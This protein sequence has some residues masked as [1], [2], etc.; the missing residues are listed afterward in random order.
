MIGSRAV[1]LIQ[2]KLGW[3]SDKAAE[4]LDELQDAQQ[5]L[6][7]GVQLPAV[8]G[9]PSSLGTFLPSFLLSEISS[10]ATQ[11]GEER[12][13]I[14]TDFLDEAE[15][16]ALWYFNPS[17]DDPASVWTV[18]HKDDIDFLRGA[19]PGSGPPQAYAF[20]GTY[21]RIFPTPDAVYTLKILYYK[22]DVLLDLTTENKWLKNIPYLLIGEAG[23]ELAF[24]LRDTVA[25]QYFDKMS[26]SETV[27][28]FATEQ[29]Q[30]NT[31]RTYTMGG[32]D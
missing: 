18:L 5:R 6:E 25:V 23:R 12:V 19:F 4:I 30:I 7:Q 21:F 29:A 17:A 32:E 9:Q 20:D 1:S 13:P 27:G 26:Q 22:S 3:R 15:P 24:A 8:P 11:I 16:D 10:K 31:N 14:P 28:L 2:R